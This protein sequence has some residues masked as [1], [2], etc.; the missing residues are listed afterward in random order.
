[1]TSIPELIDLYNLSD[2]LI[3]N[4]S[5]PAH[6]ASLT[7]IPVLVMFGPETPDIY[8]PLGANV[9]PVYKRPACSPCVSVYNQKR[10]PCT[11]NVCLK[12]ITVEEILGMARE[13]LS[14][15]AAEGTG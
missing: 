1:Q 15:P 8:C 14:R 4:D 2:L 10:S 7:D 5:G 6:F 11:D 12:S 13:I 3:T 9:R